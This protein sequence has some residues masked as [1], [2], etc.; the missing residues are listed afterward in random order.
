MKKVLVTGAAGYIGSVLIRQLIEKGYSVRA[1]DSLEFGGE[2]IV[3]LL[4][5]PRFE[6]IKGNISNMKTIEDATKG[7][8][9]VV[10]LAAIVGDNACAKD[11]EKSHMINFN[12]TKSLYTISDANEVSQFIFASTCSNYG[13]MDDTQQFVDENSPLSPISIYAETK[14]SAERFLLGQ[15]PTNCCKPTC[16]RFATVYGLSPRTRFDLTVNEFT[17]ELSMKRELTIF[18]EQ[19]WRPYCHVRDISN[20]I[21]SALESESY[22]VAFDVFNVGDSDENYTKGM[23][24]TEIQRLIP[25]SVLHYIQKDE[26]PRNYK[27]S[28]EKIK[29]TLGFKS[30]RRLH[31]GIREIKTAVLDGL[32]LNVDDPK[33]RNV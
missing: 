32:F 16:L 1:L 10:H 6:F 13:K 18:G 4:S 8:D 30:T 19:F 28:F 15:P 33:Y 5:D 23:L 27:V 31:D 14:V 2:S 21:I 26:D 22:D 12:S 25:H 11:P 3:D 9:G 24:I 17:K 29:K 7:V 20:A